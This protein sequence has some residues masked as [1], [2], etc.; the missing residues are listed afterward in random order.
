MQKLANTYTDGLNLLYLKTNITV[1][2]LKNILQ[3]LVSINL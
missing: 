3:V 1:S 2:S